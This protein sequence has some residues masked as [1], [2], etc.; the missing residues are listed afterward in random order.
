VVGDR[1]EG[2]EHSDNVIFAKYSSHEVAERIRAQIG[3]GRY[4]P[5]HRF[6]DGHASRK[7]AAELARLDYP[8]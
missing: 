7:I 2:R 6:G 1:Q 5:D 8:C 3:H 4:R